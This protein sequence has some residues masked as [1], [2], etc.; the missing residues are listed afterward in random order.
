MHDGITAPSETELFAPAER[1]RLV[2]LCAYFSGSA[3]A[4]EDLAQETL[5]EAWRSRDRL[6][7]NSARAQW[8]SGIACNVCRRWQHR[9]SRSGSPAHT[10]MVEDVEIHL[11]D[12]TDLDLA[13]E[14]SEV[15]GLVGRALNLLP[16][17]SRDLLVERYVEDLPAGEMAARRRISEGAAAVRLSRGKCP[18]RNILS[19]ELRQEAVALGVFD[20]PPDDWQSTR[21]WCPC[22]GTARLLA[23]QDTSTGTFAVRC[24][25]CG[26]RTSDR[27]AAY[28]GQVRGFWRTLLRAHREADRYYRDG[29]AAGAAPC[30]CCGRSSRV[31]YAIP[32]DVTGLD[33][34]APGVHIRCDGCGAISFQPALGLA[35]THPIVQQFWREHKRIRLGSRHQTESGGRAAILIRFDSMARKESVEVVAAADTYEVLHAGGSGVKQEVQG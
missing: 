4:A 18:L 23:Q 2:R 15:A 31:R 10:V 26:H 32:P 28:V 8:L 24:P 12:D 5:L 17:G 20:Q 27:S 14:R 11:A 6:R 30:A 22:C 1:D 34:D 9:Q 21:I 33:R 16:A 19:T 25:G 3:A 13:L 29:L 7:D 35:L